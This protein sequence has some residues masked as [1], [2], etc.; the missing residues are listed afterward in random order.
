MSDEKTIRI[1]TF[2]GKKD[3]WNMW[4]EKFLAKASI[5][6][7]DEILDGTRKCPPDN[8]ATLTDVEKVSRELNK[9]AYNELVLSATDDVTSGIIKG[10]KYGDI[11]KGD[12]YD[13]WTSYGDHVVT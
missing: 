7:F 2:S 3:D 5:K 6:G 8:Q 11:K 13:A 12:A 4:A 10:A 9:R 1:L